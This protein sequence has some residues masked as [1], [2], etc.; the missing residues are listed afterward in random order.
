MLER[1]FTIKIALLKKTFFY[2]MIFL[3]VLNKARGKH[4]MNFDPIKFSEK[5]KEYNDSPKGGIGTLNERCLHRI[6]KNYYDDDRAHHEIK[7]CGFVADIVNNY[8]VTEIQ[9]NNFSSLNKKLG[10]YL[11]YHDVTVVYPVS[12]IKHIVWI[13]PQTGEITARNKS[14]KVGTGAEFLY[15]ASRIRSHL[16]NKRL[17]FD[18]LLIDMDEYRLQNGWSRDGKRGSVRADRRPLSLYG[19]VKINTASDLKKLLPADMPD[20]SFTL[21]DFEKVMKMKGITAK[22]SLNALIE[23][24][25]VEVCGKD[26][27]CVLYRLS[28]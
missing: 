1:F 22:F 4:P 13:N 8:G 18:I 10:E 28:V 26:G 7:I 9:T 6:I 24:G 23:F 25:A 12:H 2:A 27:R 14:P 17:H 3:N 5:I 19:T 16:K 20:G 11:K 21:K 15:E